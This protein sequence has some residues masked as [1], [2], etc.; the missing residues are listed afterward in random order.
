M[1]MCIQKKKDKHINY[2][3]VVEGNFMGVMLGELFGVFL[4]DP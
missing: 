4:I 3:V 1:V 2:Y